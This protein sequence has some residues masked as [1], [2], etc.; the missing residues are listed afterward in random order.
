V[1][2]FE[3]D[4]RAVRIKQPVTSFHPFPD[5]SRNVYNPKRWRRP[6]M[7]AISATVSGEK[8]YLRIRE[9]SRRYPRS[10]SPIAVRPS[11]SQWHRLQPMSSP[12]IQHHSQKP[13]ATK[14]RQKKD[15]R[16]ARE[17]ARCIRTLTR[18][19]GPTSPY[20]RGVQ[21]REWPVAEATRTSTMSPASIPGEAGNAAVLN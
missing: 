6:K 10:A 8:A 2:L 21:V 18:P 14:S 1:D 16:V 15:S 9:K 20:G 11:E 17:D 19:S 3:P 12:A 5:R 13:C 4:L 7:S